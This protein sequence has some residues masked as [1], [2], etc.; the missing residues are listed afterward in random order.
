MILCVDSSARELVLAL[1]DSEK[2][3][4]KAELWLDGPLTHGQMLMPSIQF[5]LQQTK[6]EISGLAICVGPGSFTGLRVGLATVQ[7]L[8]FSKNLPIVGL[9]SLQIMAANQGE[10]PHTVWAIMDARQNMLYAAPF[11]WQ[12]G[13][14]LRL[15]EDGAARVERLLELIDKP[16][17]LVGSGAM[18]YAEAFQQAGLTVQPA[19]TVRGETLARLA[20]QAFMRKEQ[21][22]PEQ[23]KPNYCRPS[24]AEASFGIPLEKYNLL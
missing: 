10:L 7:G 18:T 3:Q 9:S 8:A 16:A 20:A 22:S 13:Q 14:L 24:D 17:F 6:G 23:L 19:R 12:D 4:L 1:W 5:L 2:Q 11:S 21:V 15:A